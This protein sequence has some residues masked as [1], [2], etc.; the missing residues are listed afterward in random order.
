MAASLYNPFLP[1]LLFLP[2]LA[3]LGLVPLSAR[4]AAYHVVDLGALTQWPN[5]NSEAFGVNDSGMVVGNVLYGGVHG[6]W[7]KPGQ[8]SHPVGP[9]ARF[10]HDC[11][12]TRV[13]NS[14]VATGS[15]PWIVRPQAFHF[16]PGHGLQGLGILQLPGHSEGW[17]INERGDVAGTSFYDNGFDLV[18][19]AFYWSQETGM[20][21]VPLL[22]Q[23]GESHG[24]GL[25]ALGTV[26]G[27]SSIT[28]GGIKRSR[29]IR[30][31]QKGGT[32]N[33]GVLAG[34]N[35]S[36]GYAVNSSGTVVGHCTTPG[37]DDLG[38]YWTEKAGMVQF[39]QHC[40]PFAVSDHGEIIGTVGALGPF[41]YTTVTG[42]V[43]LNQNLDMASMGW[44]LN[45][46]ND[47]NESGWIVG[48]GSLNGHL[49]AY[50]AIPQ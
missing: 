8:G 22:E 14:D 40:R 25:N 35:D 19:Q 38:F 50:L 11:E 39:A 3:F 10:F 43:V 18:P 41:S 28:V 20:I 24:F 47:V 7:W 26:V 27:Y 4:A 49:S 46:A 44:H 36:F 13:N 37:F 15:T 1:R 45:T 9:L 17:D 21:G 33:L 48:R 16:R 29:A 34:C 32:Q 31:S 2:L 23:G 30:W 6:W 42:T 12:P 5:D